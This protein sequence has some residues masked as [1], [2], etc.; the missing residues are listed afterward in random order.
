MPRRGRHSGL[1]RRN[2]ATE[3]F[4]SGASAGLLAIGAV[5]RLLGWAAFSPLAGF[6][7]LPFQSIR[8]GG[9]GLSFPSHHRSP[10]GVRATFVKI[11]SWA[12]IF[13]ALGLDFSLVPGTTPKYPFSGL[14]A[15]SRPVGPV[16]I[17]AMSSPIV[18]SFQPW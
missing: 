15:C 4:T 17:H 18:V 16:F 14:M 10:S 13:I 12:M 7:G 8:L 3:W 1:L 5:K 2:D 9:G 11:V 6:H